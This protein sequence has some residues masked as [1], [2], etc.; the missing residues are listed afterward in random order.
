MSGD[1]SKNSDVIIWLNAC[2]GKWL[3]ENSAI[4]NVSAIESDNCITLELDD[5]HF[6]ISQ[7]EIDEISTVKEDINKIGVKNIKVENEFI[8]NIFIYDNDSIIIPIVSNNNELNLDRNKTQIS[9][10]SGKESKSFECCIETGLSWRVIYILLISKFSYL[11]INTND[12]ESKLELLDIFNQ[13]SYLVINYENI[14]I[15]NE[16][17]CNISLNAIYYFNDIN[18]TLLMPIGICSSNSLTFFN[19]INTENADDD[20][21]KKI[22]FNSYDSE[23]LIYYLIAQMH[24]DFRFVYLDLYHVLEYYFDRVSLASIRKIIKQ[25]LEEPSIY[26][27]DESIHKLAVDVKN[28]VVVDKGNYKETQSLSLLLDMIG[29]EDIVKSIGKIDTDKIEL[30]FPKLKDSEDEELKQLKINFDLRNRKYKINNAEMTSEKVLQRIRDR[31]YAIRNAIAHSKEEFQWR[32]KPSS[33]EIALL[34]GKDLELIKYCS[35]EIIKKFKNNA[36]F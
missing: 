6:E 28:I 5:K 18:N 35:S 26:F 22:P 3:K 30:I 1:K 15:N 12:I 9:L 16:K 25:G 21:I 36:G 2:L 14:E 33:R 34:K 23:A 7:S 31:I 4:E 11:T 20:E 13:F 24:D 32:L 19:I 29:I 10:I 27:D 8:E 17:K